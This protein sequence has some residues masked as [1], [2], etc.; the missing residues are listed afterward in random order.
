MIVASVA[1]AFPEHVYDQEV[2]AAALKRHWGPRL[3][4]PELLDR[5]HSR[6]RVKR[7]HLALGLADY[8]RLTTWG[9]SNRAW[10]DAAQVLGERAIDA[11]LARAGLDR[12]DL[13]ALY[14]VS[15]TGI[16]SPS[17]DAR[18]INRMRLRTDIKR[19]PIFGVGCAGGAIGLVRAA[20]Y[21]RA[22]PDQVCALLSV[23]LCSLT[24]RHDDHSML[25]VVA[26]GLF[27]DGAAAAILSGSDTGAKGP[28]VLATRS[29]FYPDTEDIMGWDIS[30]KGFGIVLSPRLPQLIE[31]RSQATWLP[32]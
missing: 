4:K 32:F 11:A 1:S 12:A 21:V 29:I 31:S 3:S 18:L 26:T 30:E 13:D 19:T 9:E 6:T 2:I 16:A 5:I 17:L 14:V 22:Y 10:M 20:D 8:P 25:N 23:E 28:Q 24:M 15:V 7:R 27:A